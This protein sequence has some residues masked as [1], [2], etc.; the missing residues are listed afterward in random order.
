MMDK[1]GADPGVGWVLVL[2]FMGLTSLPLVFQVPL[3]F[4]LGANPGV[5]VVGGGGGSGVYRLDITSPGI[6]GTPLLQTRGESRGG[7][8]GGG[9]WGL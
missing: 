4:R 1:Q 3:Y 2:G 8:W 7:G 9:V 5:V 6:S